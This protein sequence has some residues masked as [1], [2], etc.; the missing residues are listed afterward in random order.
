MHFANV[1]NWHEILS[2]QDPDLAVEKLIELINECTDKATI[3]N[4]KKWYNKQRVPR[5]KPLL[6]ALAECFVEEN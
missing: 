1:S 6:T 2:V 3:N 5:K 4:N